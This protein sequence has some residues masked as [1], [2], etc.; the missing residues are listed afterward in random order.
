MA[1]IVLITGGGRSGK[2]SYAQRLAE[3]LPGPRI[4]V[5]T[6]V[7][8]DRELQERIAKHRESRGDESWSTIEEPL[9]LVDAIGEAAD[10]A[11]ILV[12]CLTMWVGNLVWTTEARAAEDGGAEPGTAEDGSTPA[13]PMNPDV[14]SACEQIVAAA[15]S[16]TASS[17]VSPTRWDSVSSPRTLSP[18][19]TGICSAAATR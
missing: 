6:A 5:A 17:Y 14:A 1:K 2:S 4:Y 3:S 11:T 18:G 13:A 12:D 16:A 9:H 10:P 15:G 7:P 8:F 19:C